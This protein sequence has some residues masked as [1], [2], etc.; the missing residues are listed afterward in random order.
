MSTIIAGHFQLQDEIADARLALLDAGFAAAR[1]SSFY[2]NPPGQHDVYELGG[3]HDKS[4]GARESDEGVVKGGATGA[5]AGAVVG[6][7]TI[8]VSGPV[9]PVV[10]ALVGAHVGSLYSLHKMKEAGEPDADGSNQQ[11]PRKSGM[12][13]AVAVDDAAHEQRA[14]E[15]LRRLGARDIERAE[16]SITGGD[17]RDFDPNSL[18]VLL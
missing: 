11:A 5:V 13:I 7:A 8:P 17:W 18:P 2:V 15:V 10:G 14:L 16:G 12:L 9:G 6:A 4:P 3:D 1:I